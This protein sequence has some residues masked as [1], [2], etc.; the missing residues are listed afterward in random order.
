VVAQHD[1][2]GGEAMRGDDGAAAEMVRR[3]NVIEMFVAQNQHVDFFRRAV[4]MMEAFQQGRIVGGQ[5]DV[6]HDGP[7]AS[8]HQIG[9]GGAVLETDLVDV[10]GRLNQRTDVI[11]Q[12]DRK[13]ARLAVAHW[14]AA[15]KV[16]ALEALKRLLSASIII[17]ANAGCWLT[18]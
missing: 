2:V 18:R 8:A 1:L 3:A 6:D 12:D 13:W 7:L 11:V 10:L 14:L 16:T 17:S 5:P 9:T 15:L 4:D